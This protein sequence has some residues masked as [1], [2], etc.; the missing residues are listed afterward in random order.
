MSFWY[1]R[2]LL[3]IRC[4]QNLI[5]H[6][7]WMTRI[8]PWNFKIKSLPNFNTKSIL[9]CNDSGIAEKLKC[10]RDRPT[11]GGIISGTKCDRD[12]QFFCQKRGQSHECSLPPPIIGV[13][14]PPRPD[15]FEKLDVKRFMYIPCWSQ[16]LKE[17]LPHNLY[18]IYESIKV[19]ALVAEVHVM[20]D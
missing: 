3:V 8:Y 12:K 19:H 1:K 16:E 20:L 15:P 11:L 17:W 10:W 4:H 6:S 13:P 14:P 7:A 18:T 9:I 2:G 5:C